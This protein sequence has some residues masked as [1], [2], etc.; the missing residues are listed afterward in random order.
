MVSAEVAEDVADWALMER[1]LLVERLV[2][3]GPCIGGREAT[4][5]SRNWDAGSRWRGFL[6]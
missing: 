6:A 1:E 3:D 5:S 4:R 2:R